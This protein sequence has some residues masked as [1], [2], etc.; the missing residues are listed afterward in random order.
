MHQ[1]DQKRFYFLNGGISKY[2]IPKKVLECKSVRD[3]L[4]CTPEN[5]QGFKICKWLTTPALQWYWFQRPWR[6]YSSGIFSKSVHSKAILYRICKWLK[7]HKK[8]I[9]LC[10]LRDTTSLKCTI[11]T[12]HSWTGWMIILPNHHLYCEHN[13]SCNNICNCQVMAIV[14]THKII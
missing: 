3:K 4:L 12:A 5:K 1:I 7:V 14:E 11:Q 9:L 2:Y 13:L 10:L 6:L 8:C